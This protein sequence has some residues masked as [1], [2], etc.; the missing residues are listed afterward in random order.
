MAELDPRF[1]RRGRKPP[2]WTRT[3]KL[4]FAGVVTVCLVGVIF[5]EFGLLRIVQLKQE[6][7][8]LHAQITEAKIRKRILERQKDELENDLTK[9]EELAREEYGLYKP[10]EKVFLFEDGDTTDKTFDQSLD[11]FSINQ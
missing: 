10:G 7:S 3:N 6:S 1:Y 8:E 11:N 2:F 4:I 5:G 9:V